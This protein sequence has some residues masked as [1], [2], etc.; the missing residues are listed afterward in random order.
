MST[1]D[2]AVDRTAQGERAKRLSE[3]VFRMRELGIVIALLLLIAVTAIL[4]PRF[5]E[6]D[7][8]KD[9]ARNASIIAIIAAGMTM[10]ILTRN[11]DLSVGSVLGL[12][13]F[14]CGDLLSNHGVPIIVAIL[15]CVL[16]GALC[17][18]INGV[19]TTFG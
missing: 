4:E 10:V 14:F 15:L 18:L 8:L 16:L 12:A 17:G 2:V 7:S 6:L 9:L 13:A 3:L 1:A 5:I 19:L 11:I